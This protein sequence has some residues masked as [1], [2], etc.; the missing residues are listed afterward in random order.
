MILGWKGCETTRATFACATLPV[1]AA[2]VR[3]AIPEP[4]DAVRRPWTVRPVTA[5]V[6]M[7]AVVATFRVVH[8]TKGTVKVSKLN[9]VLVAFD[10]NPAVNILVVVTA[11]AANT[12]P[13]TF[14]DVRVP[15]DV[16]LGWAG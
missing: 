9:T 3:F 11:L 4:L 16:M 13:E 10:E 2:A 5:T 6:A 8:A 12:F 7:L 1:I 14:R 15:T